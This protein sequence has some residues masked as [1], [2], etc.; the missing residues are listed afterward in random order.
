MEVWEYLGRSQP[1]AVTS[2]SPHPQMVTG[3]GRGL[4]G[5][6]AALCSC[7]R[8]LRTRAF[9]SPHLRRERNTL[10]KARLLPEASY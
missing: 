1:L 4:P 3:H 9:S 6:H 5:S 8:A 7:Y 10:Q 2:L